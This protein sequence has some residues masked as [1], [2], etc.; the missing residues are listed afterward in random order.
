MLIRRFQSVYTRSL[1]ETLKSEETVFEKQIK[2]FEFSKHMAKLEKLHA[3]D[4]QKQFF[5]EEKLKRIALASKE[6]V[7]DILLL[8]YKCRE[9]Y[10]SQL[11]VDC[12]E[13]M[14]KI[15]KASDINPYSDLGVKE[16]PSNWQF[17]QVMKDL[18]LALDGKEFIPPLYLAR[19]SI[20]LADIGYK[21]TE[22][23]KKMLDAI[24]KQIEMPHEPPVRQIYKHH[25]YSGFQ[26]SEEF[27]SHVSTLLEWKA[28]GKQDPEPI[29]KEIENFTES[30]HDIKYLQKNF[31]S[32]IA[33]ITEQYYLLVSA[34]QTYDFLKNNDAVTL[35]LYHLQEVLVKAGILNPY[36]L[37]DAENFE[38]L[39]KLMQRA[40]KTFTIIVKDY[41][42]YLAIPMVDTLYEATKEFSQYDIPDIEKPIVPNPNTVNAAVLGTFSIGLSK[43]MHLETACAKQQDYPNTGWGRRAKPSSHPLEEKNHLLIDLPYT[44]VWIHSKKFL[45]DVLPLARECAKNADLSSACNMLYGFGSAHVADEELFSNLSKRIQEL[46]DDITDIDILAGGITGLG[47]AFRNPEAAEVL[48][49]ILGR[50]SELEDIGFPMLIRVIWSQ[51]LFGLH[52]MPEFKKNFEL[53]NNFELL[54]L[55]KADNE[56]FR[57]VVL[58]FEHELK[59]P[60]SI[61]NQTIISAKTYGLTLMSHGIANYYNPLKPLLHKTGRFLMTQT[62]PEEEATRIHK[63]LR[64]TDKQPLFKCDD[65]IAMSGHKV[66]MFLLADDGV[67]EKHV[68]GNMEMKSRICK[69]MNT[70]ILPVP[71]YQIFTVDPFTPHINVNSFECLND[72]VA[73]FIGL[74]KNHLEKFDHFSSEF[75]KLMREEYDPIHKENAAVVMLEEILGAYKVQSLARTKTTQSSYKQGLEEIKLQLFKCYHRYKELSKEGQKTLNTLAQ[76][77]SNEKSFLD[78]IKKIND[79][80]EVPQEIK[81]DF[82]TAYRLNM[83]LPSPKSIATPDITD[84]VI[85]QGFLMLS[86]YFHYR[87]WALEITAGFPMHT[88]MSLYEDDLFN[89]FFF[90]HRRQ[91]IGCLPYPIHKT[92]SLNEH[93]KKETKIKAF[94][95]NLKYELKRNFSDKAIIEK[96]LGMKIL[97]E[98]MK[99]HLNPAEAVRLILKRDPVAYTEFL[100]NQIKTREDTDHYAKF[101]REVYAKETLKKELFDKTLKNIKAVNKKRELDIMEK[102]Q[103]NKEAI[104]KYTNTRE[105]IDMNDPEEG[106]YMNPIFRQSFAYKADFRTLR[107]RVFDIREDPDFMK[108]DNDKDFLN[109]KKRKAEANLLKMRVLL[110]LHNNTPLSQIESEYLSEYKDALKVASINEAGS[111]M[112]PYNITSLKFS[113]L[114]DEDKLVYEGLHKVISPEEFKEY[115]LNEYLFE[116]SHFIDDYLIRRLEFNIIEQKDL[117]DWGIPVDPTGGSKLKPLWKNKGLWWQNA[118][119]DEYLW[120]KASDLS[121]KDKED[122]LK[123]YGYHQNKSFMELVYWR[124]D[125]GSFKDLMEEAKGCDFKLRFVKQWWRRKVAERKNRLTIPDGK[126][127]L[128]DKQIFEYKKSEI[129]ERAKVIL[130][131]QFD[132]EYDELNETGLNKLFLKLKNIINERGNNFDMDLFKVVYFHP[133][134]NERVKEE[135]YAIAQNLKLEIYDGEYVFANPIRVRGDR[136]TEEISKEAW[137]KRIENASVNFL[138]QLIQKLLV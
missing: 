131:N 37:E 127:A 11:I 66:Y 70:R 125:T 15:L 53:L 31:A 88:D 56:F 9:D 91:Q 74:P 24:R 86:D 6:P 65:L 108:F 118:A 36:E 104:W 58:C 22:I 136:L 55:N 63:K 5:T 14:G 115:S 122:F 71:M 34:H 76:E 103:Y 68:L 126:F 134:L 35:G 106:I 100:H 123:L 132:I 73:Q 80:I 41:F 119:M 92:N 111:V 129:A 30:I 102:L 10:S 98:V 23:V 7:R 107:K 52:A 121:E 48:L 77:Q 54:T 90:I 109:F 117:K 60:E 38:N 97:E 19:V 2:F 44:N 85:N 28:R 62:L 4:Q 72:Y 3:E 49:K 46:K 67:Y 42:P 8:Y 130:K 75:V 138:P 59:I 32:A 69:F 82:W 27:K 81:T 64:E 78:L 112:V 47:L 57:E 79:E 21:D 120:R 99:D 113:D 1:Y 128:P 94:L 40:E 26:D 50:H 39:E 43:L 61:L 33:N 84:E 20:A 135:M 116:L 83:H 45:V 133:K 105:A 17:Q 114:P 18:S 13:Y 137:Q 51:C 124:M 93:I 12:L 29:L 16:L 87:D 95:N 110:K 101:Y 96:I 89:N 25:I